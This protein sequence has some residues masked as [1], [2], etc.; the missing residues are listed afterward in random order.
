MTRDVV[1]FLWMSQSKVMCKFVMSVLEGYWF[2]MLHPHDV[3]GANPDL[4]PKPQ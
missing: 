4:C 3:K 1:M 2:Y